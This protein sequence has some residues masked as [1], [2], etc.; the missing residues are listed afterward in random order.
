[1][2]VSRGFT[3]LAAVAL[4]GVACEDDA[5]GI[6]AGLEVYTATLTG[7][8]ERPTPVTTTATGHAVVTILGDSLISFEV[9]IDSPMDSIT[10][11][12]IHRFNPD[13]GFGGV[14]LFLIPNGT[15]PGPLDFTGTVAIGSATPV[16]SIFDII[17]DGRAYVNI[18]T[19]VNGGGE[20]RGNLVKQ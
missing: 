4:L 7:A 2:R 11:G 6:P 8:N 14:V 18:H 9:V 10:A 20:I 16:D 3:V 15:P 17:R 1:M 12:H 5:T 13:T 19:K